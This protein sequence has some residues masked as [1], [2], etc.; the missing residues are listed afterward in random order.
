MAAKAAN[1]VLQYET[2]MGLSFDLGLW[3]VSSKRGYEAKDGE[4]VEVRLANVIRLER[5]IRSQPLG[6]ERGGRCLAAG[7]FYQQLAEAFHDRLALLVGLNGEVVEFH[8]IGVEVVQFD[9]VLAF[10]PVRVA[11][12]LGAYAASHDGL[13]E[14]VVRRAQDLG[15]GV[16]VPWGDGVLQ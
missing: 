7:F 5:R 13:G 14:A 9:T 11:P 3:M 6:V 15:D 1:F 10:S 2:F 16:S 4:R 8:R 12:A